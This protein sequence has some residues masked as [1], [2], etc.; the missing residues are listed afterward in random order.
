M[1]NHSTT[2][3]FAATPDQ[4]SKNSNHSIDRR[5][6]IGG[7][8]TAALGIT[9]IPRHVL[10]GRGFVAPSDKIN[11][12]YI[13]C[14]TQGLRE[15]I[16]LLE[17]PDVHITSVCDPQQKAINYYDW[18][19]T[20]LRDDIRQT[21][22]KP[23]WNT[24][25]NN[26]IPGGRDN[27]KELVEGFYAHQRSDRKY[28]G[29]RT[30]ADF[31]EL[32]EKETDIDAVKIMT[33][34]HVHGIIAMAALNRNIA[35]TMHKPIAN[36][37]IEGK[38]VIDTALK[39]D[40]VTHLIAWDSNGNMDQIMAWINGGSIGTL[41]EIHNWSY[42]PVWPQY[43]QIPKDKPA[44]PEGFDWD[45]WLGP[46][47]E[48][49]YHP[50]YT[51]MVFRGWYDFGGGSMADM[52]HYSL[53]CVFNA[54][55]LE[56]PIIV[57]PNFS[58]VCDLDENATA[59][60]IQNDFAFPFAS[61]VRF[62]YP[63]KGNRPAVDLVWYEGGMRPPTPKEFYDRNIEFPSEGMMFV[64][65][66]GIIMSSEFLVREPY[67]LSGDVKAA[68]DVPPAAGA[69]KQPGNQ[70]FIEGIKTGTQIDGSFRQAW[71]ITEAVNLYAAALRSGKT[72]KY[73]AS[74]LKITNEEDAN[75]YLDREYRKGWE[76]NKI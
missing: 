47:S 33:T 4:D 66:K 9:L 67:L 52:G 20:S 8:A 35:V 32:F 58:H 2:P 60:K 71:P 76:I 12:A 69:T 74:Q 6:F 39:S 62:K 57:E 23:G 27:A 5:T 28:K 45:L 17:Q 72:L 50:H 73:D 53:W 14:G 65:D 44:I 70:R 24:G 38:K 36:R 34:D 19:P 46:E 43:A 59:Y 64:G 63:A 56:N 31:R 42:R 41:K 54:L 3:D 18:G 11:M 48:R 37:L 68:R 51:N 55:E 75:K 7:V 13:G 22:G 21:I 16:D 40:A 26:T 61:T 49:A 29:C 1:S 15:M 10:G 25:G 30:Y